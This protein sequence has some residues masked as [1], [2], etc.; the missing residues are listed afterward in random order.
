MGAISV[1]D[2][3]GS[4][5]QTQIFVADIRERI[6]E[7]KAA[8]REAQQNGGQLGEDEG[9]EYIA[10]VEFLAEGHRVTGH[11]EFRIVPDESFEEHT[12][13]ELRE[14]YGEAPIDA[15]GTYVDWERLA[16]A[17]Q[18]DWRQVDFGDDL[19]WVR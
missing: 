4:S 14:I 6:E 19:V 12:R 16:N 15:L 10:L 2:H 7:L 3:L 13:E 11:E 5:N 17:Y 9:Q 1:D 8:I 18:Q